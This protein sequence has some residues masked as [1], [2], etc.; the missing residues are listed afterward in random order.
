MLLEMSWVLRLR[1]FDLS[2]SRY[3]KRPSVSALGV[4]DG[5][6]SLQP[7][8]LFALSEDFPLESQGGLEFDIAVP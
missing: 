4:P 5:S 2:G 6:R 3:S 1:R 7:K 8:V